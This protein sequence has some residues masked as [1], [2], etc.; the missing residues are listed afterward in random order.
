VVQRGNA[1]LT[2]KSDAIASLRD[3]LAREIVGAW[4][5]MRP[6][7]V[8][9]TGKDVESEGV[10]TGGSEGVVVKVEGR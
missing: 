3:E 2:G 5:E 10:H 4:G 8:Q 7:V 9:I 1:Y 6:Y